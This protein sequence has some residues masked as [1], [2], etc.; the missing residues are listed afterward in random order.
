M[1]M[2]YLSYCYINRPLFG[3]FHSGENRGASRPFGRNRQF[4]DDKSLWQGEAYH[5]VKSDYQPVW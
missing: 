2:C 3:C 5:G 1:L 4:G